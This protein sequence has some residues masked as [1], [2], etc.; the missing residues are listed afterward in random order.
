MKRTR[1][2]CRVFKK[3][4]MIKENKTSKII[5]IETVE[6]IIEENQIEIMNAIR[7]KP[8]PKPVYSLKIKCIIQIQNWAL[9]LIG[10]IDT[11]CSN[12]ILDKKISATTIS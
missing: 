5:P 12:T 4:H 6:T 1:L 8:K 10:L 7:K 11:G 2:A 9:A 3:L